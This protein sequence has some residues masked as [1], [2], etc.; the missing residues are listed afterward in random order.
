MLRYALFL[1]AAAAMALPAA[2]HSHK[3]KSLEIVHP[4]TSASAKAKDAKTARIFMTVRSVDGRPDRLVSAATPKGGK[5]VLD[6]AGKGGQAFVVGRDKEIVL[7]SD[8]PSLLL[9]GLKAPLSAYGD[10]NMMLEFEH[11]G[12][13]PIVVMVEE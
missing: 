3:T 6:D 4:W 1:L 10:F 13:V 7:H 2:A 11:A 5:V 12:R 8:G 9:T